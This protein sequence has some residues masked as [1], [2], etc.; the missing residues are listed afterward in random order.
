MNSH[1]RTCGCLRRLRSC[2]QRFVTPHPPPPTTT[3]DATQPPGSIYAMTKASLNQLA[4]NLA[5]EW[6][7]DRIRV[8][9]V[10]PWY[11]AT[12]L[13]NQVR[14]RAAAKPPAR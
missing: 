11:T 6:A 4:K 5:C 12:E 9:S 7:A 8:N 1:C 3:F 13:A 14:G 10:A 2:F